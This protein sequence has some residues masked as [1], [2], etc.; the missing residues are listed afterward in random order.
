MWIFLDLCS[1]YV[2]DFKWIVLRAEEEL[3][4]LVRRVGKLLDHIIDFCNFRILLTWIYIS[5]TWI[6]RAEFGVSGEIH[7]FP[8]LDQSVTVTLA[9]EL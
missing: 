3:E 6:F 9:D 8:Y 7:R 4:A 5:S 2:M 1:F